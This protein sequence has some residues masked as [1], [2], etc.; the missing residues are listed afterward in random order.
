M[1]TLQIISIIEGLLKMQYLDRNFK[2][3]SAARIIM[4]RAKK[5]WAWTKTAG[6]AYVHSTSSMSTYYESST[7]QNQECFELPID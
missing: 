1:V 7:D 5:T 6:P 2:K 3:I 4:L